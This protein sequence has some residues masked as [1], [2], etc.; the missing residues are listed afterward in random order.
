[1]AKL[2]LDLHVHSSQSPDA[3]HSVAA[4]E[5]RAE[6][7]G[8][9]GVAITDHDVF[10]PDRFKRLR[11]DTDLLILPAVEMTSQVG[12][13]LG[14][15]VSKP[16]ENQTR[17]P[18]AILDEIQDQGGLAVL[19][20]PYRGSLQ[21]GTDFLDR[22][23]GIELLNGRS[24]DPDREETPNHRTASYLDGTRDWLQTGGS[25]AHFPWELGNVV[26]EV[27]AEPT[28]D[29]VREAF[30]QRQ[31]DVVPC[32]NRRSGLFSRGLSGMLRRLRPTYWF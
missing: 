12:H 2:T 32:Y 18:M 22:L 14:L 19:A 1:M 17:D 10:R 28:L 29:A 3:I 30:Q 27:E 8:V 26:T 23:D 9:D 21:Y 6:K 20:H 24:G 15:F 25:D 5:R 13:I 7:R 11:E 16:I 31:N 4:M